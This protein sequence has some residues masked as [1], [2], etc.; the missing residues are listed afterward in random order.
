MK[1][2]FSVCLIALL[3]ISIFWGCNKSGSSVAPVSEAS[4]SAE[5]QVQAQPVPTPIDWIDTQGVGTDSAKMT[6]DSLSGKYILNA[7]IN[8]QSYQEVYEPATRF[9]ATLQPEV[10]LDKDSQLYQYSYALSN[11]AGPED[12]ESFEIIQEVE[13]NDIHPTEGWVFDE[14]TFANPFGGWMIKTPGS[15]VIKDFIRNPTK[16]KAEA[17]KKLGVKPGTSETFSFNTQTPPGVVEA[18]IYGT[19]G[20]NPQENEKP[21]GLN[22]KILDF[23]FGENFYYVKVS[24][25]G[26]QAVSGLS[27]AGFSERIADLNRQAL[28]LKW[29]SPECA[30]EMEGALQKSLSA[31]KRGAGREEIASALSLLE[32]MKTENRI[33]NNYYYL[34]KANLQFLAGLDARAEVNIPRF[35]PDDTVCREHMRNLQ[36]CIESYY[37][38]HDYYPPI[39]PQVKSYDLTGM[40]ILRCPI[41][42]TPY[43]YE[44]RMNPPAYTIYCR[45]NH[46]NRSAE[47][48]TLSR[49]GAPDRGNK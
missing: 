24:T 14:A 1:I 32:Q 17:F 25:L 19:G 47:D 21:G 44:T 7:T 29:V 28:E 16:E 30:K 26:P 49:H 5:T 8:G 11:I 40:D 43:A 45:A 13:F 39:L 2:K 12:I 36:I 18:R 3:M 4:V 10:H 46:K 34:I 15:S 6:Y 38:S 9:Q 42:N 35:P 37:Y 20:I 41:G 48:L 23:T 27:R 31:V 22:K 33:R